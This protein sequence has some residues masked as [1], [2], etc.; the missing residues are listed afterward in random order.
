LRVV[1]GAGRRSRASSLSTTV[2]HRRKLSRLAFE[3][4]LRRAAGEQN[5]RKPVSRLR[6]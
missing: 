6:A 5:P 1:G 4:P 2:A 3:R